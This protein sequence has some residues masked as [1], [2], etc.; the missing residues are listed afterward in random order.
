MPTTNQGNLMSATR[1]YRNALYIETATETIGTAIATAQNLVNA[2]GAVLP[3]HYP[4]AEVDD[5]LDRMMT[6]R[7]ELSELVQ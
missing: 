4:T 5:V 7:K 1:E 3:D 2:L 6:L